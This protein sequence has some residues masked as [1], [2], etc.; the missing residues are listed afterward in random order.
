[1]DHQ[2]QVTIKFQSITC[3]IE[4][5]NLTTKT[6]LQSYSRQS[7]QDL[8]NEHSH[9]PL[10]ELQSLDANYMV[11]KGLILSTTNKWDKLGESIFLMSKICIESARDKIWLIY[12]GFLFIVAQL[13]LTNMVKLLYGNTLDNVDGGD[14]YNK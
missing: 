6:V 5:K 11:A 7:R 12:G 4:N 8:L 10:C 13:Y 2:N 1:M 9:H 14:C 3:W